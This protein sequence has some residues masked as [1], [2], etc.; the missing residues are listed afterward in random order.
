MGTVIDSSGNVYATGVFEG[1]VDF[2]PGLGVQNLISNSGSQDIFVAKFSSSGD[3]IWAFRIGGSDYDRSEGIGIGPAGNIYITGEADNAD[4]DPGPGNVGVGDVGAVV[5]K[6]D[7]NGNFIWA[8]VTSSGASPTALAVDASGAVYVV[9]MLGGSVDFDPGVGVFNLSDPGEAPFVWKLDSNGNFGFAAHAPSGMENDGFALGVTVD[10]AGNIYVTGYFQGTRDFDPSGSQALATQNG[11]N[12][13][14]WK[15][16][17]T[18]SLAWVVIFPQL[19][20]LPELSGVE[21]SGWGVL[22]DASGGVYL[23]G[24]FQGTVDFDPANT[25]V[26]RTSVG[27]EDAF[28]LKLSSNGNLLWITQFGSVGFDLALGMKFDSQN[29]GLFV[30]GGFSDT[31]DF[32]PSPAVKAFTASTGNVGGYLL[33][34]NLDGGFRFA[35]GLVGSGAIAPFGLAV[36]PSGI[37]HLAGAFLGTIDFDPGPGTASLTSP[38]GIDAFVFRFDEDFISVLDSVWVDFGHVGVENGEYDFPYNSLGEGVTSV[39]IGGNVYVKGDS[40]DTNSSE[41]ITLLVPVRIQAIGGTIRIG[42][43]P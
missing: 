22:A 12:A 32:D 13:F 23:S 21:S 27:D 29:G 15:L 36:G 14:L 1:T 10:S 4:L 28:V 6:F 11:E 41:T 38:S 26:N 18:A 43:A 34:L 17:N 8:R 30:S 2:D 33:G 3:L 24:M 16:T 37:P 7:P 31:V 42:V 19:D 9:G 20:T 40:A 39:A 35:H 25:V 5:I